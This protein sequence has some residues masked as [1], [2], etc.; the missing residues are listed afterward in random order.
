MQCPKCRFENPQGSTFCG[1]CG[2][3]FD[4]TCPECGTNN[5]TENKFSN[6]C[7]CNLKPVKKVFGQ[8]TQTISPPA[9]P[10][11]KAK[12]TDIPST[13]GEH[14]HVTVLLSEL[15]KYTAMS[16]KLDPEEVKEITSQIFGEL[17]WISGNG[18][19]YAFL[20]LH[21]FRNLSAATWK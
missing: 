6:E 20:R 16:E 18:P 11:K 1:S 4:L 3:K 15:I 21:P 14:K 17:M 13:I 5:P 9:S 19:M 7:G 10:I 2:H 8:T 12:G